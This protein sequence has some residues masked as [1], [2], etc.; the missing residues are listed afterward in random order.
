MVTIWNNYTK[1]LV[2]VVDNFEDAKSFC[3][4]MARKLN[5]GI[6]R[7][8]EQDGVS[9]FDCGPRTYKVKLGSTFTD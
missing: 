1:N 4:R 6:Y 5:Y 2:L 3:G 9:Y 7:Y 8:W